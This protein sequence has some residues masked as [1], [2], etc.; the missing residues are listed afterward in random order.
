MSK[1]KAE[2]SRGKDKDKNKY[3]V[4]GENINSCGSHLAW[5]FQT[6][7]V[8]LIGNLPFLWKQPNTY[9]HDMV[10]FDLLV[11]TINEISL[12]HLRCCEFWPTCD[13]YWKELITCKIG[14]VHFD[15]PASSYR[16]AMSS[17]GTEALG[18]SCFPSSCCSVVQITFSDEKFLELYFGSTS[19]INAL[20]EPHPNSPV[21]DFREVYMWKVSWICKKRVFERFRNILYKENEEELFCLWYAVSAWRIGSCSSVGTGSY[22]IKT[23]NNVNRWA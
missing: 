17:C 19:P 5:L 3:K 10:H 7:S 13:T 22:S 2:P 12:R 16:F 4:T 14:M 15:P 1:D 11:T 18:G 8:S 21:L 6:L 9:R 20:F 23:E